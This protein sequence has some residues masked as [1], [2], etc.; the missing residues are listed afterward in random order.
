MF[1]YPRVC[2]TQIEAVNVEWRPIEKYSLTA[3]CLSHV[4]KDKNRIW[5]RL[6]RW[7][8]IAVVGERKVAD[9][10]DR[11]KQIFEISILWLLQRFCVDVHILKTYTVWT[12]EQERNVE[13]V[14]L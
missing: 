10:V 13:N 5:A 14:G 12:L 4:I 8:D 6:A 2:L 9:F 7:N 11:R 1:R 3:S